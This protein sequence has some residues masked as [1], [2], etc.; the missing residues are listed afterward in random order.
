MFGHNEELCVKRYFLLEYTLGAARV[1]ED[2]F[3]K[4]CAVFFVDD[5]RE[6]QLWAAMQNET[7]RSVDDEKEYMRYL[8]IDRYCDMMRLPQPATEEAAAMIAVKGEALVAA[9][10]AGFCSARENT[11]ATRFKALKTSADGGSV[12]ALGV[13]GLVL[14]EGL[15]GKADCAEGSKNLRKAAKWNDTESILAL[16]HYDETRRE[17]NM[18]RLLAATQYA[19][20]DDVYALAARAYGEVAAPLPE[21][22]LLEKV[23]KTGKIKRM[24]Y[25]APVARVVGSTLLTLSAK[26]KTLLSD[27]KEAFGEMCDLP[28]KLKYAPIALR[29]D[30]ATVADARQ[31]EWRRILRRLK[32]NDLRTQDTYLPLCISSDS[33]Y[34]LERCAEDIART[35]AEANVVRIEVA[36]LCDADVDPSR[37]NVF[38]RSC[39]ENRDNVYLFFLRGEPSER[40][41]GAIKDFL[42]GR[43]RKNYRLLRPDAVVDLGAILPICLCDRSNARDLAG[44]VDTVSL[45]AESESEKEEMLRDVLRRKQIQY[46]IP[47]WEWE[48][49]AFAALRELSIDGATRVLD[50]AACMYRE[51]GMPL[52]LS[53]ERIRRCLLG[54]KGNAYGFGEERKVSE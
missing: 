7:V 8:R 19:P 36:D 22:A 23:F 27:A 38:V 20:Y 44:A 47:D 33:A 9:S 24:Q 40:V 16:L 48:D 12:A 1:T 50:K 43:K 5:A 28:L 41:C 49:G 32:N 42:S 11:E 46:G 31:N 15:L 37:G 39:N 34:L 52:R 25:D 4:L 35:F 54:K 2:T 14:C 30:A 6:K 45:A 53:G 13:L 10:D 3:Q 26:E 21:A 18:R 17:E 51:S 29:E